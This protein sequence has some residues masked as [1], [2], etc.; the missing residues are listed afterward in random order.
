V[1]FVNSICTSGGGTHV[2][3]IANQIVQKLI[4]EVEKKHKKIQLK[5]QI[6]RQNLYLFVNSLIVNPGFKSQTKEIL[7][8]KVSDFGSKC[9]IGDDFIKKLLKTGI[10]DQIVMLYENRMKA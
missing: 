9:E 1:S 8:T 4:K 3:H 2:D 5:P 10:V 7:S 6:V